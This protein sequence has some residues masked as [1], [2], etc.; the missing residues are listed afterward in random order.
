MFWEWSRGNWDVQKQKSILF[1]FKFH[2]NITKSTSLQKPIATTTFSRS[3]S[4]Y[5]LLFCSPVYLVIFTILSFT[6]RSTLSEN[7]N[8]QK[9]RD[10]TFWR[11]LSFLPFS[12]SFASRFSHFLNRSERSWW[13]RGVRLQVPFSYHKDC[14]WGNVNWTQ[15]C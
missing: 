3:L 6:S 7:A 4:K 14:F 9:W 15:T 12:F 10:H 11:L 8:S 1:F 5:P 13:K 2:Q